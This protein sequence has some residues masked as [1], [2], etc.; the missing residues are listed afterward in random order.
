V[1]LNPDVIVAGATS[2]ALAAYTVT[3][4]IPIVMILPEDPVA[5]GYAQSTARP[6]GNVTGTWNLVD[7]ALMG[8]GLDFFKLAVPSL[9]RVG[10]LFN[11]DDP[12]DG[13]QIPRLP[14]AARAI[15]VTIEFIEVRNL[16]HLDAVTTRVMG[17]NVQGVFVG[18]APFWLSARTD[19]TAMMARLKLP[20]MFSWREFTDSGGLMSYG[21]NLPD[22]YRTAARLVDRIL[23][24]AKPG[25]LPFEIPTRYELIVN[26][27]TA[28]A[29]GLNIS[30]SFLLLAD[31]VIE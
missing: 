16:S 20:A 15:G 5:A 1:A 12:T 29:M 31:E 21:C 4:T 13:V 8:K 27:K 24:G 19:I 9:A 11:P 18:I 3:R 23:K 7:D 30:D 17:A 25:D 22:M 10:A 14:A 2:G 28:K 6:G 26:L